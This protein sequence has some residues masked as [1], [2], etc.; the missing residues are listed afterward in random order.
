MGACGS[1]ERARRLKIKT[2]ARHQVTEAAR[3]LAVAFLDDPVAVYLVPRTKKHRA[4]KLTAY[5]L[6]SITSTGLETVDVALTE[7]DEVLAVAIWEAPNHRA[8][9]LKALVEFPR[10]LLSLGFRG[11]RELGRFVA[12]SEG[13]HPKQPCWHLVDIGS[14]PAARGKGVG[15]GLISHRLAAI[16]EDPAPVSL[17]ATTPGSARLYKKFGFEA[18]V[19]LTAGPAS[20]STVMWRE[21]DN[22][23]TTRE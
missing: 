20:G 14:N 17:E 8:H 7:E 18:K 21:P 11:L 16:D 9:H 6:W 10:V 3:V 5:F 4:S 22:T 15:S 23:Q 13:H 1:P 12:A 19:T 2:I